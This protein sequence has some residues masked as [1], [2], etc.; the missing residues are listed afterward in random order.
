MTDP[1]LGRFE[2][3]LAWFR[4]HAAAD[5][6]VRCVWVGGSAATGGWDQ[7]S[8]LDVVVLTRGGASVAA[9][10]R[11][12]REVRERFAPDH[13]WELPEAARPDGRQCF[14]NP[15]PRAG[16]LDE[17]TRIVDLAVLDVSDGHRLV[18]V[19]R[20]GTPL[21]LHDPD[22]LVE[23]RHDDPAALE[24]GAAEA[25]DQIRQRFATAE[26]LVNRATARG[27]LP[28]AVALYLRFGL[29]PLVQL[30]RVEHCPWR[31]DYGLRYLHTDLPEAVAARVTALLP[32]A[33]RLAELSAECFAWQAELLDGSDP[34]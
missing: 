23:L 9:Y 30:L 6:D 5:P 34:G 27:H 17:P 4:E 7:W 10:E 11:L 3:W 16:R 12:L 20:H 21:V 8:D 13:V 29:M 25:V 26:W 19:R 1:D 14:V 31:H 2:D 15:Q 22:G 33:D 32:G 24:A 18:D 28:E